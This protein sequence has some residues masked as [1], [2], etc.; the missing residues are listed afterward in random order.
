MS[1]DAGGDANNLSDPLDVIIDKLLRY[2]LCRLSED[3]NERVSV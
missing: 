3:T 2:V 1:D